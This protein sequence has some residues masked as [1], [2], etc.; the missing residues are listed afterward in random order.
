MQEEDVVGSVLF[1]RTWCRE[2][3]IMRVRMLILLFFVVVICLVGGRLGNSL[4]KRL[5]SLRVEPVACPSAVFPNASAESVSILMLGD[6]RVQLW[7]EPKVG[8]GYFVINAAVGGYTTAQVRIQT[9]ICGLPAADYAFVQVGI[10]D[11]YSSCFLDVDRD[12]VVAKAKHNIEEM[13][14]KL[15]GVVRVLVLSTVA[16]PGT[17]DLIRRMYVDERLW[18]D[19]AELNRFI[20]NLCRRNGYRLIDLN[21]LLSGHDKRRLDEKFV[22]RDFFL[23]FNEKAYGVLD[24]EFGRIIKGEACER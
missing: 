8:A 7:R 17:P 5:H 19:V 9:E 2:G 6:S 14:R 10:N 1:F 13:A 3:S 20:V 23:H 15:S 12:V 21:G 18:D 22:D 11:V 24:I 4:L 16:P